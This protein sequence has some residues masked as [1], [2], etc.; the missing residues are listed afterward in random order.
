MN[1][2]PL[3]LKHSEVILF[4]DDT[5][6]YTSSKNI[7]QLYA[8]INSDLADLIEWFRANKLSLNTSKTHYM[9]F[10][11]VKGVYN[12]VQHTVKIDS[13]VIARKHHCKFL[14]IMI[15][16][17]LN[18]SEHINYIHSKLSKSLYALNCS[19]HL[20]PTSYHEDTVRQPHSFIS[21]IWDITMGFDISNIHETIGSNTKKSIRSIYNAPYNS[22]TTIT[23]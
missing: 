23:V 13:D 6:L 7:V 14:G 4:A 5:T 22:H 3:C 11:H 10:S 1:D 19:K 16:D 18:W 12:S 21:H 8:D 15:D 2:L 9:L 17:K 20:I